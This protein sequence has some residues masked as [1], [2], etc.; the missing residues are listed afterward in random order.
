MVF[1]EIMED[2][3]KKTTE[4]TKKL[5]LLYVEDDEQTRE[6][7]KDIFEL[8][9]K[10]V[11]TAED[12]LEALEKY[13][14][15]EFDLVITDIT[16]PKMNGME[17]AEEILK[18]SPLQHIIVMTAHNTDEN[19]RESIDFHIDGF[20]L[21][22]VSLEK[23]FSLLYKI[24]SSILAVKKET[25][26]SDC[27]KCFDD[28]VKAFFLVVIYKYDELTN[29]FGGSVKE[30]IW[31]RVKEHLDDYGFKKDT[32]FNLHHGAGLY[33][34]KEY[35]LDDVLSKIQTV[36]KNPNTIIAEFNNIKILLETG[37]CVVIPKQ[38]IS[39]IDEKRLDEH[40]NSTID[41]MKNNDTYFHTVRM[42]FDLQEAKKLSSLNW[43]ETTIHAVEQETIVPFYQKIVDINTFEVLSYEVYSRI[44]QDDSYI[45]PEFFI[46]LSKKAG[47]L[48]DISRA[49]FKKA[50]ERMSGNE[51]YIDINLSGM[52]LK[53]DVI[54]NY[55][56]YLCSEYNVQSDRVVLN[57]LNDE[58][59]KYHKSGIETLLK[60]KGLGFKICVKEFATKSI[61]V[62]ILSELEPDF[63]KINAELFKSIESSLRID[64]VIRFLISFAKE[65]DAKTIL[66]EVEDKNILNTAKEYGFDYV[67]GF[68][69]GESSY[70]L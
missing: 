9:F 30:H 12:G 10:E 36:S 37:Y 18:T 69:V 23:L 57:I 35:E 70:E 7:Y 28:N 5:S 26:K 21:K 33:G 29:Q 45:L 60:L 50:F 53:S 65:S 24:C 17:L 54:K 56:L 48:E 41:D 38:E 43:L 42:D 20:L 22:P 47:I 34:I 2:L 51:Y 16:M 3:R 27:R 4:M 19:L 25:N 46:D 44:K 1:G 40:I 14:K 52:D 58:L 13:K 6:Q 63:F 55:L 64:K 32:F 68:F 31:D 8:L 62:F 61:D 67:Q 11:V 39:S 59:S 15:K 49:V 66:V